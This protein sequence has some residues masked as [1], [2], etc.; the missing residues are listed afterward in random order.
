L[1]SMKRYFESISSSF[2]NTSS[3]FRLFSGRFMNPST[4]SLQS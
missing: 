4:S 2:F 1:I 3:A